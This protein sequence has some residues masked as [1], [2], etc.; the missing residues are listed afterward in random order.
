MT[1]TT[2]G[3]W[4][5]ITGR[6]RWPVM[7][8]NLKRWGP[9]V[10]VVVL[11]GLGI[12]QTSVAGRLDDGRLA[13]MHLV[14]GILFAI[15]AT[16]LIFHEAFGDAVLHRAQILTFLIGLVWYSL[17]ALNGFVLDLNADK[18]KWDLL[19]GVACGV[20]FLVSLAYQIK[21]DTEK[22]QG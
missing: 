16:V 2:S 1:V 5:T 17:Q 8:T 21:K 15:P 14:I 3:Y 13:T 20:L 18:Q 7:T 6:R 10:L 12:W 4:N 9:A 22:F 19:R 11:M